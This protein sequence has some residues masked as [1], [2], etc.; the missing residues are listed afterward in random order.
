MIEEI[1]NYDVEV[2]LAF[3]KVIHE[4]DMKDILDNGRTQQQLECFLNPE[5]I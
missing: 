2:V 1:K 5:Q 4:D 3:L